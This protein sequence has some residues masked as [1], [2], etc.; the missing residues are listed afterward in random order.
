MPSP[1]LPI[2]YFAFYRFDFFRRDTL[3][4][5]FGILHAY[6]FL[7]S[8]IPV[9]TLHNFRKTGGGSGTGYQGW[10]TGPA[11]SFVSAVQT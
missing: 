1:D 9:P 11:I 10:S 5:R 2:V 8:L 6:Y 4:R 3:Y 7:L